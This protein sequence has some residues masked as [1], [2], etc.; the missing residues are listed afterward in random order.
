[1]SGLDKNKSLNKIYLLWSRPLAGLLD[2]YTF[3]SLLKEGEKRTDR[4]IIS[5]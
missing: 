4:G 3:L 2:P 5:T 1:M